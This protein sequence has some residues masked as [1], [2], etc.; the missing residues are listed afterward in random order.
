M[1]K[2]H[3]ILFLTREQYGYHIDSYKYCFYLNNDFNI[4]YICLDQGSKKITTPGVN[5]IYISKD[6]NKIKRYLRFLKT[7]QKEIRIG[8]YNLVFIIY[9]FGCSILKV[10]NPK[11]LFNLDI[12]TAAVEKNKV[13][14]YYLDFILK[15]EIKFFSHISVIGNALGK[16][17]NLKNFH[18]LPLG[19]ECFSE[20]NKSKEGLK[21][22]Y[23]GTLENRNIIIFVKAFHLFLQQF[24]ELENKE[25]YTLTII[26]NSNLGEKEEIKNYIKTNSLEKNIKL[27][28]YISND[29]LGIYF[30]QANVGVCFIPKTN[31]FQNQPSTKIFEYTLSGL[32]VLATNTKENAKLISEINGIL[33]EDNIND[34]KEGINK[35]R[36]LLPRFNELEIKSEFKNHLW[37]N[38][39]FNNFKAYVIL[40]ISNK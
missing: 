12:R 40:L 28:G 8:N 38:I 9:F 30:D 33:I 25:S 22:L 14:N 27:L 15:L 18:V 37:K 26:G 23:V 2:K 39:S 31:Y 36:K 16:Q 32:P 1:Q 3:S 4:T 34:T 24:D 17:L 35:I 5:C 6:G 11:Q 20:K 19:G 13:L 29:K 7:I 10:F 21:F